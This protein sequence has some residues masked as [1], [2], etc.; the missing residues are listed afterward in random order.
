MRGQSLWRKRELSLWEQSYCAALLSFW[1]CN[2]ADK[3]C[4]LWYYY[5]N[6]PNRFGYLRAAL[7]G[8]WDHVSRSCHVGFCSHAESSWTVQHCIWLEP[9]PAG[10]KAW[11]RIR[12]SLSNRITKVLHYSPMRWPRKAQVSLS[13]SGRITQVLAE[14]DKT[15]LRTIIN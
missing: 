7:W 11:A 1:L 8:G 14:M 15:R 12:S 2:T 3:F 10:T 13:N 4:S 6:P 5:I 9:P